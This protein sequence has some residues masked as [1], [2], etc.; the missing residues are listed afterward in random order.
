MC[1]FRFN[2][3]SRNLKTVR[4]ILMMATFFS[5]KF[6]LGCNYITNGSANRNFAA[7]TNQK[8]IWY[9]K[10]GQNLQRIYKI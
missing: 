4:S 6:E 8:R 1:T 3:A 10:H 9:P 7:P 2:A 5:S